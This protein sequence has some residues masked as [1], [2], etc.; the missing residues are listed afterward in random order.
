MKRLTA[1][2]LSAALATAGCSHGTAATEPAPQQPQASAP[3][4]PA[5]PEAAKAPQLPPPTGAN[6]LSGTVEAFTAA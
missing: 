1:L 2:T 6:L 4:A 5:Q 3:E